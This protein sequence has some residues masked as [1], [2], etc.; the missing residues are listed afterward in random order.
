MRA[1]SCWMFGRRFTQAW[2]SLPLLGSGERFDR[3]AT[4][5]RS[6]DAGARVA[7]ACV[8][9]L[10][11]GNWERVTGVA[12][13]GQWPV[14]SELTIIKHHQ[15][16]AHPCVLSRTTSDAAKRRKIEETG[17]EGFSLIELIIVV[18]IIGILAA[19]ALAALRPDPEECR[20]WRN[21]VG[22]QERGDHCRRRYRAGTPPRTRRHA[23]SDDR[24]QDGLRRDLTLTT[25]AGRPR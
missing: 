7:R 18:V 21:R 5:S 9:A 3:E 1:I 25:R 20:R 8:V 2:I 17:E 12:E 15:G 10:L 24:D 22:D 11:W 4:R 14:E 23:T 6:G 16:V 19:I 13:T